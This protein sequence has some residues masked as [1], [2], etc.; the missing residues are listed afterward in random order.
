MSCRLPLNFSGGSHELQASAI[1]WWSK[2]D[3]SSTDMMIGTAR[4]VKGRLL[5]ILV[6]TWPRK[7]SS[8]SKGKRSEKKDSQS[9]NSGTASLTHDDVHEGSVVSSSLQ[10]PEELA[11]H[12]SFAPRK[13]SPVAVAQRISPLVSPPFV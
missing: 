2:P 6:R 8:F 1:P 4:S 13:M 12:Y 3:K 10:R 5:P 9:E 11:Y 7:S